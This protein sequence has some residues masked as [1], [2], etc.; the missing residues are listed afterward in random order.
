[1]N[2]NWF[3]GRDFAPAADFHLLRAAYDAAENKGIDTR[4]G[5][6]VSNDTFYD[7]DGF[8]SF[9]QFIAHGV[10]A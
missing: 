3:D 5:G 2:R 9:K 1:M 8:D 4:V 7:R 6:I 10:L